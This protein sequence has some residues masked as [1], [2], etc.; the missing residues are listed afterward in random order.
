LVQLIWGCG[1]SLGR[2]RAIAKVLT[3]REKREAK[4]PIYSSRP[5]PQIPHFLP[6]GPIS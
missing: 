2:E 1:K 3:S 6:L 4:I 5:H